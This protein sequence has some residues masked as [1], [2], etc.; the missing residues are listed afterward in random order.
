MTEA[1]GGVIRGLRGSGGGHVGCTAYSGYD[2]GDTTW[3]LAAS[4]QLIQA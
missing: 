1:A 2:G 3:I 4:G